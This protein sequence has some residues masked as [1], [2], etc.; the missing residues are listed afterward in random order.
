[1]QQ[2]TLNI[3]TENTILNTQSFFSKMLSNI[4]GLFGYIYMIV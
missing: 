1:M 3:S 2:T 4:K